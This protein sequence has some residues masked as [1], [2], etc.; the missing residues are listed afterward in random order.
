MT[1]EELHVRLRGIAVG[2]LVRF[3]GDGITLVFERAYA[4]MADRPTSSLSFLDPSGEIR[5]SPR[6]TTRR[7]PPYFANR[8]S[9]GQ[10]R[11]YLAARAAVNETRDYPL[12]RLTAEDLPGAVE[13]VPDPSPRP[14]VGIAVARA[15]RWAE[16]TMD[17]FARLGDR[18]GVGDEAVVRPAVE[19]IDRFRQVWA[20]ETG[21]LPASDRV[22]TA[23]DRQ[24]ATVPAVTGP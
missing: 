17:E 12:L 8:L 19:T 7:A 24:I 2:T 18:I 13:L 20:K 1:V 10:L 23:I 5:E 11:A 15:K 9:E 6:T 22:R 21:H 16:S 14:G 3:D 4:E